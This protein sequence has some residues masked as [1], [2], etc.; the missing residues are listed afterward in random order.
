MIIN[1]QKLKPAS[2]TKE[3]RMNTAEEE[4]ATGLRFNNIYNL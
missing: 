1:F 3:E 4:N 2:P